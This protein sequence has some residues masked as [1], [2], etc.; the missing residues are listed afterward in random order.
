MSQ[1]FGVGPFISMSGELG[2]RSPR[3]VRTATRT[4][5]PDADPILTSAP[6]RNER[7]IFRLFMQQFGNPSEHSTWT[8]N[9]T[10]NN[11]QLV[12]R[13]IVLQDWLTVLF[14]GR[15]FENAR[16]LRQHLELCMK[17]VESLI[18]DATRYNRPRVTTMRLQQLRHQLQGGGFLSPPWVAPPEQRPVQ[19]PEQVI[20]VSLGLQNAPGSLVTAFRPQNDG[21]ITTLIHTILHAVHGTAGPEAPTQSSY[22]DVSSIEQEHRDKRSKAW[23]P[24]TESIKDHEEW[25]CPLTRDVLRDPVVASDGH[26]YERSHIERWLVEHETS[27]MTGEKLRHTHLTENHALR[28]AIERFCDQCNQTHA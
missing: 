15:R 12:A 6:S 1:T 24:D 2:N 3:G 22:E 14:S 8:I 20:H 27:P 5:A 10:E 21:D 7:E 9:P 16:G 19:R 17:E 4:L 18:E 13:L 11:T 25:I 26:S 28:S 23:R